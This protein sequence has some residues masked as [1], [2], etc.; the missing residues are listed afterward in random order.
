MDVISVKN[1]DDSHFHILEMKKKGIDIDN[2]VTDWSKQG[3][4]R[5]IDIGVDE[6]SFSIRKSF[7]NKYNFI[8]HAVGIHPNMSGGNVKLR[9]EKLENELNQPGINKI[10]AVGET[11]LDYYWKDV[12]KSTQQSFFRAHIELSI[13]YNKPVIIH[14]RDASE[15]I[16]NI[17][18]EFKGRI[19]GIIHCFSATE[20]Y[21]K[22][23]VNLGFYISFAGNVTYKKNT[24][25]Q[26]CLRIVPLDRILIET[27]SPY[28]PPTPKRGRLNTPNNIKYTFDYISEQL[29]EPELRSILNKNLNNIFELKEDI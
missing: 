11:G 2:V 4:K 28:L 7:S 25:L 22:E 23:F 10:V 3:G 13:K 18:K 19:R 17:L 6:N 27:D 20:Y 9:M 29:E 16:L 21:L 14:N 1:L 15:D 8:F 24:E 12:E 26:N 5:L